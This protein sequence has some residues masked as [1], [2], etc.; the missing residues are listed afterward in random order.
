[1]KPSCVY[2][3]RPR[4]ITIHGFNIWDDGLDTIDRLNPHI[5]NKG[6]KLLQYEYGWRGLIGVRL[7]NGRDADKLIEICGEKDTI[8]SHSNGCAITARAIEDGLCVAKVI[9]IHPALDKNWKA[10]DSFKG[11]IVVYHSP[12][13]KVTWLSKFLLLHRWGEMGTVGSKYYKSINDGYRHSEG[14]IRNP[15]LYTENL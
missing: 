1:M 13:D 5:R 9:F 8:I 7:F 10:P 14:F 15:K 2:K 3:E 12:K 11:E 6:Y 4:V